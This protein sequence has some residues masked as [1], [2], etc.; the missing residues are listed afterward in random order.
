MRLIHVTDPHLSTLDDERLAS[1]SGK[2]WSGYLSWRKNRRKQ[3]LPSV[4]EKL[5]EAVRTEKADQVLCTGD[6]VH[7]GLATEIAQATQWLTT[8]APVEQLML[9]P[10]NHDVYARGSAE[11]VF[12]DWSDYLF[13][14]VQPPGS[15][16]LTSQFPTVS[17]VGRMSLV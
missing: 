1:L 3:Y 5:T 6:L 10:G 11:S 2:R 8:L 7:I 4:L 13:Q 17:K 12:E 14:G 9:V 15:K 16:D